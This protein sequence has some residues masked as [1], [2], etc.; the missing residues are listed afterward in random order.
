MTVTPIIRPATAW[1]EDRVHA[2]W[3]AA[4]KA[5]IAAL[6]RQAGWSRGRLRR[7]IPA[8]QAGQQLDQPAGQVIMARPPL[9][10]VMAGLALGAVGVGLAGIGAAATVTYSLATGGLLLGAL[11]A[12]ADVMALIMPAA[13]CA[14]WRMRR[15]LLTLCAWGMW[16]LG[17]MFTAANLAGYVG[18][19]ADTF[20]GARELQSTERSL[21]LERLERLR[22]ERRAIS[23]AR[24]AGAI[25]IAIRE[26]RRSEQ[27]E[28]RTALETAK[29][30]DVVDADLRELESKISTLPAVSMADPSARTLADILRVPSELDLR[31]LR[32]ALCLVLPLSAGFL[33]ALGAAIG[34]GQR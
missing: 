15:R 6:A 31:R 33:V 30:R 3:A 32:L 2:A 13:G 5:S 9:G 21:V 26:A 19:H 4:P 10:R 17:V 25:A 27:P 23:E 20:T 22:T 18:Q 11:A 24:P 34:R 14:L 8:W 16:I 12:A 28:L 1:D 29:R 7:R